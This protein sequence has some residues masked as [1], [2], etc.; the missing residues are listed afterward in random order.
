MQF[1]SCASRHLRV[2]QK[3]GNQR[4][5]HPLTCPC[6]VSHISRQCVGIGEKTSTLDVSHVSH[7]PSYLLSSQYLTSCRAIEILWHPRCQFSLSVRRLPWAECE[8][9]EEHPVLNRDLQKDAP[10]NPS[11]KSTPECLA[12]FR[13]FRHWWTV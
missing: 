11:W 13:P 8:S 12:K 9:W 5:F 7:Q 1:R 3:F 10:V 6:A 4:R 2:A